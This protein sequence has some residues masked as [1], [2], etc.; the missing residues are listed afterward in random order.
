MFPSRVDTK[1]VMG[2]AI[3]YVLFV[4]GSLSACSSASSS[5]SSGDP[6]SGFSVQSRL[7]LTATLVNGFTSL[8]PA[9]VV[10]PGPTAGSEPTADDASPGD[11]TYAVS[12]CVLTVSCTYEAPVSETLNVSP[13]IMT[14]SARVTA[15]GNALAGTE[16][17]TVPVVDQAAQ[18]CTYNL[19]GTFD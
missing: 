17:V 5:S 1:R 9:S 2:V 15:T 12:G 8:C 16:T 13:P 14:L 11:C 3:A 18:S 4:L 6:C 10:P 7:S 19:A